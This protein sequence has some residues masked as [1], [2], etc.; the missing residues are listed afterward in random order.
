MFCAKCGFRLEEQQSFCPSC[1]TSCGS[2]QSS[3]QI[4]QSNEVIRT[5]NC[6]GANRVG[7]VIGKISIIVLGVYY[8]IMGLIPIIMGI[9][10]QTGGMVVLGLGILLVSIGLFLIF[11]PKFISKCLGR[12]CYVHNSEITGIT[13][14]SNKLESISYTVAY[15]DITSVQMQTKGGQLF[16][17]THNGQVHIRSIDKREL[18]WL[19]QFLLSRIPKHK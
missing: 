7:L 13:R 6:A 15:Q 18:D 2:N 17:N 16:L 10:S 4:S 9:A 19:Y 8:C 14:G 11:L 5:I 12:V 1:G 3:I